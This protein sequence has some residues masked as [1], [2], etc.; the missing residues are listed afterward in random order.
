MTNRT[1]LVTLL[2]GVTLHLVLVFLGLS[3]FLVI[4]KKSRFMTLI[5]SL[6]KSLLLASAILLLVVLGQASQ[7]FYSLNELRYQTLVYWQLV[8]PEQDALTY[9][10]IDRCMSDSSK[11]HDNTYEASLYDCGN[12]IGAG[13]LVKELKKTDQMLE[14]FAWPLYLAKPILP[15]DG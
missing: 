11:Y 14:R 7:Y 10:F 12:K 9:R 3:G 15:L 1:H 2:I 4:Q 6:M 5:K 13:D 8:H